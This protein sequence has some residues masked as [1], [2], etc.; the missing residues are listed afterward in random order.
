[1]GINNK[2]YFMLIKI[3]KRAV[4][5]AE[6]RNDICERCSGEQASEG[7]VMCKSCLVDCD[8]G[9]HEHLMAAEND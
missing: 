9:S 1:M 2:I 3:T 4:N 8:K 5:M 6:I 7:Q